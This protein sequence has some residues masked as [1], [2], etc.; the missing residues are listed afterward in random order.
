MAAAHD[1]GRLLPARLLRDFGACIIALRAEHGMSMA[2]YEP[3]PAVIPRFAGF[4]L[5]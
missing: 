2:S 1:L 5:R 3:I 4:R